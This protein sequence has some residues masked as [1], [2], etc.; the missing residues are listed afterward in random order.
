MYINFVML[1]AVTITSEGIL[2]SKNARE[3]W[4]KRF[5]NCYIQ[6][7]LLK[8]DEKI[9]AAIDLIANDDKQ[10]MAFNK[11]VRFYCD[12]IMF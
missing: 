3:Q 6:P 5:N 11:N 9:G 8:L 1:I 2:S 4:E 7:I 10:S 12:I